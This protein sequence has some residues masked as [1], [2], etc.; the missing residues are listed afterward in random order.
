MGEFADDI[1]DSLIGEEC[2]GFRWFRQPRRQ[3]LVK[4]CNRCGE[5]D[6]RWG[7][8]KGGPLAASPH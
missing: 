2:W 8:V 5:S 6:L 7:N 4:T 1:V 3:A